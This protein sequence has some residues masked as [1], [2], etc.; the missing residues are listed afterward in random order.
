LYL[1]AEMLI[2]QIESYLIQ[3]I[4][5]NTEELKKVGVK[6]KNYKMKN[7]KWHVTIVKKGEEEIIIV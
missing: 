7:D 4:I 3:N 5:K 1:A 6:I 2:T